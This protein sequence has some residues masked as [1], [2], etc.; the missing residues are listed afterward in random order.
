[1]LHLVM[2]EAIAR[3]RKVGV[4]LVD[5]EAQYKLTIEHSLACFEMYKDHIQPL[6]VSLPLHLR[7]AVSVYEPFWMCWDP[8]AKD[9]W[10]R[11]P[12]EFAITSENYFPFFTRGME[13][14]EFVPAF[15]EWY[16]NGIRRHSSS[17]SER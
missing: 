10:V 9:A 14:E 8:D 11:Q 6:W 4:L 7:N 16:S 3:G 17:A 12:P 2:E 1:M 15:A 13:F 5:L